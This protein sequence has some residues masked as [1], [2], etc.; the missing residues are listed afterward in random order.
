MMKISNL[1]AVRSIN[2][3]AS[4]VFLSVFLWGCSALPVP[5]ASTALYDFGGVASVDPTTGSS[6]GTIARRSVVAV[7]PV[8]STGLL[9]TSTMM[10]YRLAYAGS[11]QL[12]PYA[13]ARWSQPPATLVQQHLRAQLGLQRVVLDT[14]DGVVL[15]SS[16][17][18]GADQQPRKQPSDRP[19]ASTADFTVG[20][21][22]AV[23]AQP[24]P[25]HASPAISEA[26]PWLVRVELDAFNQVFTAPNTS[27]GIV[28]WRATVFRP[29]ALGEQLVGQQVFTAQRPAPTADA[30]GGALALAQATADAAKA[31][32]AWL[33]TL[34]TSLPS[35]P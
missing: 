25:A 2:T 6:N 4:A 16:K 35:L 15:P 20:G 21:G 12:R 3:S 24:Q 27:S 22:F 8:V 26:Q 13:Q 28:R 33:V 11:Q 5:P 10:Y 18:I 19:D 29:H 31:L 1:I 7:A 34:E 14:V 23:G 30:A 17:P 9:D 32:D